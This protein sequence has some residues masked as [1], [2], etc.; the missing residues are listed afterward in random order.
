MKNGAFEG[1]AGAEKTNIVLWKRG[2]DNGL[3]GKQRIKEDG[4]EDKIVKLLT[5]TA[6][7][8]KPMELQEL[9]KCVK[10]KGGFNK[11]RY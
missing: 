4:C 11:I 1:V 3:E 6:D 7:I 10:N 2:Y 9:F 8:Q 5:D